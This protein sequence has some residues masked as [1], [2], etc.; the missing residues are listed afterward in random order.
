MASDPALAPSRLAHGHGQIPH[1][2][3]QGWRVGMV[4]CVDWL[5]DHH[6]FPRTVCKDLSQAS[7]SFWR[8]KEGLRQ[9]WVPAC[10]QP[11]ASFCWKPSPLGE[12]SSPVA[13][14]QKE[15]RLVSIQCCLQ[16]LTATLQQTRSEASCRVRES[17]LGSGPA[18]T[19]KWGSSGKLFNSGSL[20]SPIRKMDPV[21]G[22][23]GM[24]TRIRKGPGM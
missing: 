24:T 20:G 17:E 16:S 10:P 7:E 21:D 22:P 13:Q 6:P 2:L 11:P 18:S 9:P 23:C 15:H 1:W 19:C 8:P 4:G 12:P 3:R 5:L 14:N